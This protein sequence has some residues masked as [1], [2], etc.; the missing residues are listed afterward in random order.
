MMYVV[1]GVCYAAS[2]A[3]EIKVKDATLLRGGMILVTFSN[4]EKRLFDTTLLTGSAFEPLKDEEVLKN[5]SVFHGVITWMDGE[6]DI[7]PETVYQESYPYDS[8]KSAM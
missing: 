6:I 7:E 3:K 2:E 1:D 5:M 8:L 4:G